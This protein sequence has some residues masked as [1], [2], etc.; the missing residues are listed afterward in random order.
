[1][2]WALGLVLLVVLTLAG[3]ALGLGLAVLMTAC[4]AHLGASV[5]TFGL[6][7]TMGVALGIGARRMA[8][9]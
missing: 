5:A 3:I 1:M 2:S 4:G 8:I 7:S 9:R 6:S